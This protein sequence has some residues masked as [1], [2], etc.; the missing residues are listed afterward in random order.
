MR[1]KSQISVWIAE[2]ILDLFLA[3]VSELAA[4]SWRRDPAGEQAAGELA[5]MGVRYVEYTRTSG[6]RTNI[7]FLYHGHQ[8]KLIHVF[9]E[10]RDLSHAEHGRISADFWKSGME[11]ACREFCVEGEYLPSR[12]VKPEEGLPP[13]VADAL[14][15]FAVSVN[16]EDPVSHPDDSK[17]WCNFLILLHA[18]GAVM[19]EERLSAYLTAKRFPE[20]SVM[21]M[22]MHHEVGLRLLGMYDRI[23]D[24]NPEAAVH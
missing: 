15:R 10:G 3:K 20:S 13:E 8:L 12:T 16:R 4:G 24:V 22:L 23:L 17:L 19:E 14:L 5:P 6:T 11:Q 21:T 9:T 18:T 2:D 7:V 1:K